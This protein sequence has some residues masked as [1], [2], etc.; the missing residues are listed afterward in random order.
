VEQLCLKVSLQQTAQSTFVSATIH[1][2]QTTVHLICLGTPWVCFCFEKI[3]IS[4]KLCI[5][6]AHVHKKEVTFS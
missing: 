3:D 1:G 4:I 5:S 6:T 2:T